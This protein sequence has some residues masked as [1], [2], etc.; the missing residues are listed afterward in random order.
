MSRGFICV[1]PDVGFTKTQL[2]RLLKTPEETLERANKK[3]AAL[4]MIVLYK[5]DVIGVKN[6]IRYQS[7]YDRLK[8]YKGTSNGTTKGTK[9][10]TPKSNA[11][12]IEV[13]V[14]IDNRIK[15]KNNKE[16]RPLSAHLTDG[17]FI[18]HLI[19]S[20]A[21]EGVDVTRELAKMDTWLLANK[22]RQKTRRFI[23]NWLNKIDK[24]VNTKKEST[25]L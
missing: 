25:P 23:V 19:A 1:A 22:G 5:N 4:G 15:N 20:A 14:D 2:S 24:P 12:D 3:L 8:Q 9:K 6:W 10:G 11:V 7:E 17:E 13:E 18:K 21:Y 16:R